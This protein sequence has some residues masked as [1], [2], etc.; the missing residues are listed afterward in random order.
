[1]VVVAAG[2]GTLANSARVILL[3]HA[4]SVLV[5]DILYSLFQKIQTV[6]IGLEHDKEISEPPAR[7][8][9]ELNSSRILRAC[10]QRTAGDSAHD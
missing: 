9:Y 5:S 3:V 10:F 4:M 1:L 7:R 6:N 8:L 2:V